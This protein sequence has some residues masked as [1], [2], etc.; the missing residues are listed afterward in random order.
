LQSAIQAGISFG[1]KAVNC[2]FTH[3]NDN[4]TVQAFDNFLDRMLK[5]NRTT[6]IVAAGNDAMACGGTGNVGTP[7]KAY[8]A[9]T[10]GGFDDK[11]S[12][13]WNDDSFFACQSTFGPASLWNDRNKPEV[14]APA[15]NI[16]STTT[17]SPWIDTFALGGNIGT[18][19]AAPH[20]TGEVALIM[21]QRVFHQI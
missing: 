6:I 17:S 7:G 8:G 10:V 11:N 12:V 15:V 3:I 5:N 16:R 20:V 13:S 2:S 14:I 9:I 19:F 18:S 4:S 1:A 21:S